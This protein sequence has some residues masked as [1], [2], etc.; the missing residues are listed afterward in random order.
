M[1]SRVQIFDQ[2]G[3]NHAKKQI[4][5]CRLDSTLVEIDT[6]TFQ[7][8]ISQREQQLFDIQTSKFPSSDKSRK[9]ICCFSE[10]K[11]INNTTSIVTDQH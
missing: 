7:R 9:K 1:L 4:H 3:G 8:A 2:T 6:T 11:K 5:I 10:R